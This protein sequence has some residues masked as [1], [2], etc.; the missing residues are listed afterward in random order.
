MLA[1]AVALAPFPSLSFPSLL[2]LVVV[3]VV[4]L[5]WLIKRPRQLAQTVKLLNAHGV[6][7][8]RELAQRMSQQWHEVEGE[9]AE[10]AE[11]DKGKG[12]RRRMQP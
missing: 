4:A 12:Q 2:P 10:E 5:C 3:A 6:D 11:E 1:R 8:R 7:G 9:E